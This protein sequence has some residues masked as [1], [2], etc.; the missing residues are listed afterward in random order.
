MNAPE[1]RQERAALV[2]EMVTLS[3]ANDAASQGRWREL[4]AQQ[5]SLRTQI[6]QTERSSALNTEMTQVRDTQP[7]PIRNSYG[8][9]VT[10]ESFSVDPFSDL[11]EFVPGEVRDR[12]RVSEIRSARSYAAEFDH[13]LRTG[14]VGPQ[15]RELRALGA[16]AGADGA[17][18]VPQGFEVD[19]ETK[20]KFWG[21][22][23]NI[24]RHLT[25]ATGNPLPYPTMDDTSNT[26]EFLAEAAPVTGADPTFSNVVFGA[27]LVSSK[28]V[29]V[30]VALE[31]DSAFDMASLLSDAFGERL[32]RIL[33]TAY[34]TGDGSTVPITGLLTALQAAGGRS[35]LAVGANLNDGAGSSI[36]SVGTD[37]FSNLVEKLDKGYQKPTNKFLFSQSTQN[38]LRKLKDKYGRPIWEVSLAQGN[39]DTIFGYGFQVDNA[40]AGIAAG[41]I[42]VAF[43]DFSKYIIRDVLGFT[44]VR[45]NELYMPNYQRA[46]QAF[47]RCDAKLMQ[48]AAFSY[49]THPLS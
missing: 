29:K 8:N 49:L 27:N 22:I 13:Y 28:Q 25:T 38:S 2:R 32:G 37:D 14:E 31:Q 16:A 21:G 17:T 43:G 45:F 20:I 44:L 6:E 9:E 5:E 40:V 4:D 23:T 33:D 3:Q 30:S 34:W 18:L 39:P 41:A 47:K 7:P 36:N 42:S 46:Y 48:A 26:G 1:M 15:Q 35:V 10:G 19:V 12:S 24:A 11:R